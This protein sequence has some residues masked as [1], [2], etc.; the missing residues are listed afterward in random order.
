MVC[1]GYAKRGMFVNELTRLGWNDRLL[2]M[3]A[4]AKS[5]TF[6]SL[7][8]PLFCVWTLKALEPSVDEFLF[9]TVFTLCF[10]SA[11]L[12][13]ETLTQIRALVKTKSQRLWLALLFL[14]SFFAF[15]GYPLLEENGLKWFPFSKAVY[16]CV[17]AVWFIPVFG[18]AIRGLH[19]FL[20]TRRLAPRILSW[21]T[22]G[23][24]ILALLL[25]DAV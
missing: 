5:P 10:V 1:L 22:K 24:A 23:L 18:L 7:L 19:R 11:R 6:L 12:F 13:P 16:L 17:T 2:K 25:Y 15:F 4:K 9:A 8:L 14:I 20:T 21:K 3:A